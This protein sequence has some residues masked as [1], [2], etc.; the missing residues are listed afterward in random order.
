V[1][2]SGSKI[3][4]GTAFRFRRVPAP[5]YPSRERDVIA[6]VQESKFHVVAE[7]FVVDQ[8]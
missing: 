7:I 8:K 6:N 5:L 1:R 4:A 2:R 3:F